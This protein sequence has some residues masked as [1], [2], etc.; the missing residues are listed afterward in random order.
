[1]QMEE[2]PAE[3][4]D[5]A[6]ADPADGSRPRAAYSSRQAAIRSAGDEGLATL[7]RTI[8]GEIVPRMIVGRRTAVRSSTSLRSASA[9]RRALDHEDVTELTRLLI[10]H[11]ASVAAAYVETIHTEGASMKSI[12]LGLLAPAARE[13]GWLWEQDRADFVQVTVGLCRLH[14]VLRGMSRSLRIDHVAPERGSSVLLVPTPGEQHTF[15][16]MMVAEFFRR[17]G[18]EVATEYPNRMDELLSLVSQERYTLVGLT[19][20]CEDRLDGLSGRIS[21]VRRASRNKGV[22]ILVGGRIFVDN[23]DLATRVGADASARDAGEV[24]KHAANVGTLLI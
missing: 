21:Q 2:I 4:E 11:E 8:E 14:E 6:L 23:P 20:G 12:C 18:W 7:V 17:A 13:L 3:Q 24:A 10:D 5:W 22:G 1:M 15:G 16:L 19:V 9:P